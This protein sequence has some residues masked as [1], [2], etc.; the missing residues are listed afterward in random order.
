MAI[1][2]PVKDGAPLQQGD[3]PRDVLAY[4]ATLT[5]AQAWRTQTVVVLSRNCVALRNE[6][7]VVAAVSQFRG[8][9][10]SYVAPQDNSPIASD[11]IKKL[12]RR[13]SELRDG[14]LEAPMCFVRVA[15]RPRHR[16]SESASRR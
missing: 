12:F 3:L 14:W 6:Q 11:A 5:G 9:L 16:G 10:Q 8:D 7:I 1:L 13:F 2:I 4:T 15:A